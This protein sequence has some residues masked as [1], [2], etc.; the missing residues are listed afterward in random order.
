[1]SGT[2]QTDPPTRNGALCGGAVISN[3]PPLNGKQP[4]PNRDGC[5]PSEGRFCMSNIAAPCTNCN[6]LAR[7]PGHNRLF[8]PCAP[9]PAIARDVERLARNASKAGVAP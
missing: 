1:M 4:R 6:R 9:H 5:N 3:F 8:A 2:H 7:N